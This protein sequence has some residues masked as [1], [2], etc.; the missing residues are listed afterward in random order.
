MGVLNVTPDSFSDGGRWLDGPAAI[1]HGLELATHGAD[2]VDVGGESTRPGA[3]RPPVA[4]ELR[5]VLSV[6]R[7]LAAA[8]VVVSVDTM[9]A[10]VAEQALD[11]GARMVNDVSA[12]CADPDMLSLVAAAG[13]PYVGMHWR[14]H[15][16]RMQDAAVYGD[17]VVEVIAHLRQRAE[18][19]LAAGVGPGQLVLDPGLG[20]A[21]EPA[22]N[23]AL[24]GRLAEVVALGHPVLVGASRKSFLGSLLADTVTGDP[25]PAAEREAATAAVSTLCAAAGVWCV[26][27]HEVPPNLDAVRVAARW[28]AEVR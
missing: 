24:L 4:E 17:V 16:D 6:V 27:V 10:A 9:R 7:E 26:R 13:V 25:R 3:D 1:A 11:A 8:G 5:R 19:A 23:W 20:F 12:G 15:S 28:A 18:A 2:I 14:G 22:H 21:K